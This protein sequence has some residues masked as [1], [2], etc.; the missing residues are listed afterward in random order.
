[1]TR[2]GVSLLEM[3]VALVV[4]A[5]LLVM[6]LRVQ[7]VLDRVGRSRTERAGA[8]HTLRTAAAVLGAELGTLAADSVGGADLR[9]VA[10]G[11][12]YRAGRGLWIGCGA[13]PDSV[14]LAAGPLAAWRSRLPVPGRDSLLLYLAGDS[15]SVNAWLPAPVLAAGI[16]SVCP[17]GT[18]GLAL[19]TVVDSSRLAVLRLPT[20][21]RV[22]EVVALRE[23]GSGGTWQ[24]G[25]EPRSGGGV[26][27]PVAGPLAGPGGFGV[28]YWDRAGMP[29]GAPTAAGLDVMIRSLA[30]AEVGL[31]PGWAPA[32]ADSL[33]VRV[34][35]GGIR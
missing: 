17:D 29:A 4:G 12:E 35:F 7:L 22:F 32:A 30:R 11:I 9:S 19:R 1:M 26:V 23:Y 33:F 21:V 34:P 3:L 15:G 25:L 28:S 24:L 18:A 8:A 2:R 20:V 13:G 14:V 10:G 16:G 5:V 6:A 27:Q 31:G